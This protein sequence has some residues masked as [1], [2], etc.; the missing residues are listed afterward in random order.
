MR[1]EHDA[2]EHSNFG[3]CGQPHSEK[4][5]STKYKLPTNI[6]SMHTWEHQSDKTFAQIGILPTTL[7]KSFLESPRQDASTTTT[8]GL[9]R[10]DKK[11]NSHERQQEH[12]NAA[13]RATFARSCVASRLHSFSLREERRLTSSKEGQRDCHEVPARKH[14]CRKCRP[15]SRRTCMAPEHGPG[16][17]SCNKSSTSGGTELEHRSG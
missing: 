14:T 4:I 10:N 16:P 11:R 5:T 17:A 12:S 6:I 7:R 8:I 1:Q 15:P 3:K 2:P 13:S 9:K